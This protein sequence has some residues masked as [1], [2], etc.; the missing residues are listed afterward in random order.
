MNDKHFSKGDAIRFGFGQTK[1]YFGVI[2]PLALIVIIFTAGRTML[3]HNAGGRA[4]DE[5]A[6]SKV[7]PND[8]VKK[9]VIAD[10]IRNGYFS[11]KGLRTDKLLNL[12]S[13]DELDL[14]EEFEPY[15]RKIYRYL[16]IH[17][18]RLPFPQSVYLLLVVVLWGIEMWMGMGLTRMSLQMARDERP[19]V[20]ELFSEASTLPTYMLASI[21]MGISIIGGF[22]LFVIPG[23]FLLVMLQFSGYAVI[24]E[25]KGPLQALLRSR[26]LT[27]GARWNLLAFGG[28]NLLLNL[29]GVLCLG[30]GLLFTIPTSSIALSA[31]FDHLKSA[32]DAPEAPAASEPVVNP[33]DESADPP[34]SRP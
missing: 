17:Q 3:D 24:D 13:A 28:L 16:Q 15:R 19:V 34:L 6:L 33:D 22:L 20:T 9:G 29:G 30:I 11:D 1:K 23:I 14:S 31:V 32:E 27:R 12:S 2:L 7:L 10:L 21:L 25:R 18:Y 4:V 8:T 26:D 5:L